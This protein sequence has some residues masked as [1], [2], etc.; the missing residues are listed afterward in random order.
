MESAQ[1]QFD[2]IR[3][4]PS[5]TAHVHTGLVDGVFVAD[6]DCDGIV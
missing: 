3:V 1:E 4:F 5:H 2:L 6:P